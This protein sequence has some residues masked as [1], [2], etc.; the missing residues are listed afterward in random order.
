METLIL[1]KLDYSCTVF[2]PL[3][4][5]QLKRL[6]Q[7]QNVCAGFVHRRYVK[8]IDCLSLG[9]LPLK[10]RR[11]QNLLN[12]TLKA[13]YFEQWLAY[14]KLRKHVPGRTLKSSN[15]VKLEVPLVNG[16]FQDSA[17]AVFNNL[18]GD[19]RNY[20]DFN[21]FRRKVRTHLTTTANTG[22]LA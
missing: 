6:Q 13:L 20:N 15:D 8:E 21:I 4:L 14:L 5:C 3:P 16:T 9:W 10:E 11:D 17:A 2:H 19:I 1:S 7:V 22:L 12:I 18:P